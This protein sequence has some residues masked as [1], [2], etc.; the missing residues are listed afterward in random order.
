MFTGIVLWLAMQAGTE[1]QIHDIVFGEPDSAHGTVVVNG[2][3]STSCYLNGDVYFC[4]SPEMEPEDIPAIED[5]L[6]APHPCNVP[7]Q[8]GWRITA[9]EKYQTCADKSRILLRAEDGT[10]WCHKPNTRG[11]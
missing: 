5:E 4:P 9:P 3:P 2:I 6:P 10:A 1:F 11:K 8:Y 7:S